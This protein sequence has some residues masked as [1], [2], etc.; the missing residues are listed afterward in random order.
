MNEPVF[1]IAEIGQAHDGSLGILHSYIDAVA[2][3]GVDA[4]KFQTHIAE[5]ESSEFE[6]FR[7]N[8][9]YEDATRFDY[10]KRMFFTEV[11]WREI[12]Q[13]C[14]E[15]GLEFMSSPF[16]QA[17]VD[18]LEKIGVK[19][20]KV[21]SGEVTNFLML[22]KIAKT[23]KPIILSSGMSSWAELDRAVEFIE[24]FGNELSILQCTTSYPTPP[25]RTG[26]NVLKELEHRYPNATIGLSEHTSKIYTGIAAVALR[27]KILEFHVVFDK[28]M[29]GP[30]ATSSLTIEETKQLVEGIRFIEKALQNPIDKS[31]NS[32]YL[33]LKK[34]F[35]KSLAVNK[36]LPAGSK[37]T[38]EDLEAKKPAEYGIPA[39]DYQRIIG[40]KL[41]KDK[42]K[43]EFLKPEDIEKRSWERK[44]LSEYKV[45]DRAYP[46]VGEISFKSPLE[47]DVKFLYGDPYIYITFDNFD[48]DSKLHYVWELDT[49]SKEYVLK[50]VSEDSNRL[51]QEALDR[52]QE[53][54]ERFHPT[55]K[56]FERF[57]HKYNKDTFD[58]DSKEE[59]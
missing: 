42:V 56:Y 2:T 30:D 31:D 36:D 4:I 58:A 27:A 20:Y 51:Y 33:E 13:H 37:I 29:F 14:E 24:Q 8:F 46:V 50:E 52:M 55:P 18:L 16:S 3:T 25:E 26:L 40:K 39:S 28:R 57:F 6:P 34:I 59:E 19:R 49:E 9:S 12:K 45:G 10:W 44:R 35:E 38:F 53:L 48:K 15:V 41:S 32:P 23:G 21:G 54:R 11:Q 1:I 17:A 43:Y 47:H 22:E 7:V 5:A